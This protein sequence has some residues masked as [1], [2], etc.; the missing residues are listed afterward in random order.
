MFSE[1]FVA[2]TLASP[3]LIPYPPPPSIVERNGTRVEM[4]TLV[5]NIKIYNN[6][7]CCLLRQGRVRG[8]L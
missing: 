4:E 3:L 6:A 5:E 1:L 2:L 8:V 7:W